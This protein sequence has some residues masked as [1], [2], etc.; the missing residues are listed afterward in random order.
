MLVNINFGPECGITEIEA[1][2]FAAQFGA[3]TKMRE[4]LTHIAAITTNGKLAT[5]AREAL[6]ACEPKQPGRPFRN[7]TNETVTAAIANNG[8][9][10]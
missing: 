1:R 2:Q 10:T 3:S 9:T 8:A 6:A 7:R 4:A 5:M